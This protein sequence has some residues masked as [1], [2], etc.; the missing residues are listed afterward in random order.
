MSY[1]HDSAREF[2]AESQLAILTMLC[3]AIIF[4]G[5]TY[6]AYGS[7]YGAKRLKNIIKRKREKRKARREQT[8]S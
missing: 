7:V 2:I 5:G 8:K 4:W 6:L 3:F 1:T